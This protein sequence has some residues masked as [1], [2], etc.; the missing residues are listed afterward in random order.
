MAL[1]STM[2]ELLWVTEA[3]HVTL[4][5]L[6]N[7]HTPPQTTRS[8]VSKFL[9][10]ELGT[11]THTLSSSAYHCRCRNREPEARTEAR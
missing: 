7:N 4:C 5:P 2:I 3:G 11:L 9:R 10:A 6:S 1:N 8:E